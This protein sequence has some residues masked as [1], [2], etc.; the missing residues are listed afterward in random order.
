MSMTGCWQL[1]TRTPPWPLP[2]RMHNSKLRAQSHSGTPI[3]MRCRSHR[4]ERGP[5]LIADSGETER[6]FLLM[7]CLAQCTELS[8]EMY[9]KD[10]RGLS[11][12]DN[13]VLNTEQGDTLNTACWGYSS[14]R[15]ACSRIK[16]IKQTK[17]G[18]TSI[19]PRT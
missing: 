18:T 14:S 13:Q 1:N 19:E 15:E 12:S 11:R 2:N 6:P 16:I 7:P 9:C 4:S 3:P 17:H 5:R 8:A 10:S